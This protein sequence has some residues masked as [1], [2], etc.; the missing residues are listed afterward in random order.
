[1]L[2]YQELPQAATIFQSSDLSG[3]STKKNNSSEA[4]D[5]NVSPKGDISK[6]AERVEREALRLRLQPPAFRATAKGLE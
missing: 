5:G 2:H 4:M 3:I 1:M 6:V